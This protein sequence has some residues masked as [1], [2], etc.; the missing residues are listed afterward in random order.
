M[1]IRYK[2]NFYEEYK[3]NV[4]SQ[5]GEDGI[6]QEILRRLGIKKGYACEFGAWDGK[7]LS[8]TFKLVMEGF[9]AVYIESDKDRYMD[10]LKTTSE[11]PPGKIIPINAMVNQ[12]R[13][14]TCLDNLLKNTGIPKDFDVLSI[15]VDSYDYQIWNT[16]QD[17][18]PKIV[19][20]EI[21]SGIAPNTPEHIHTPGKY[22]GTAFQPMYELG[23]KKGYTFFLHTGNMIF[24]HN[25]HIDKLTLDYSD[26]LENFVRRF[27]PKEEKEVYSFLNK[28]EEKKEFVSAES[29]YVQKVRCKLREGRVKF[30]TD[31]CKD[32][33][34]LHIG[35]ADWPVFNP[36]NNLHVQVSQVN[37]NV[38]GYDIDKETIGKM[39][40]LPQ[41]KN[42][43]FHT[44]LPNKKYDFLLVP[45]TIEHVDNPG[46]FLR[47]LVPLTHSKTQILLTAPNAFCTT[48]AKEIQI[49]QSGGNAEFRELVHPDHKCWYS[50]YTLYNTVRNAY[51]KH[52]LVVNEVGVL[53]NQTMAYVIYKI[54]LE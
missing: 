32:K 6:L 45:E 36:N 8:N 11:F 42:S 47:S 23:L 29:F 16:V 44:E 15:D 17:Y 20:V 19:V 9:T 54:M 22:Q 1:S 43:V 46:E 3:A 4:F 51:K 34:V 35:C 53:D 14:G 33:S 49:K 18:K 26:P 13:K 50:P 12:E 27:L 48:W 39:R 30:I 38:E 7:H 21:N 37:P 31:L 25:D 40:T 52:N 28:T 10:L 2:N 41:F 5:N 24:I